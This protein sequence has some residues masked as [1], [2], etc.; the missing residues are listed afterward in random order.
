MF[1]IH[2]LSFLG[3]VQVTNYIRFGN[4]LEIQILYFYYLLKFSIFVLQNL[5]SKE[6]QGKIVIIEDKSLFIPN[7][8]ENISSDIIPKQRV[9]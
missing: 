9:F 8:T 6:R 2:R 4:S 3:S 7:K 5:K 1:G